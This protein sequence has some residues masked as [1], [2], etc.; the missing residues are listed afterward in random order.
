[1]WLWNYILREFITITNSNDFRGEENKTSF[2][3]IVF[4]INHGIMKP[5]LWYILKT[6]PL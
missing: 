4:D 5:K 2:G 1:M 3:K 6:A